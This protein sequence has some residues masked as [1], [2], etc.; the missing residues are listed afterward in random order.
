MARD[1]KVIVSLMAIHSSHFLR[2]RSIFTVQMRKNSK[3]VARY[4]IHLGVGLRTCKL[5]GSVFV[6]FVCLL[7][8]FSSVI[9]S[10]IFGKSSSSAPSSLNS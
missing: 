8:E 4:L 3:E 1:R 6:H 10:N 7:V 2:F 5:K 9:H